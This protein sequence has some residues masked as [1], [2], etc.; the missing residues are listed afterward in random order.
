[1]V[2]SPEH[3]QKAAQR[4]GCP[5]PK[6]CALVGVGI[7]IGTLGGRSGPIHHALKI[8]RSNIQ[9]TAP[10]HSEEIVDVLADD[11]Q[12]D[13]SRKPAAGR[14]SAMQRILAREADR[15]GD[16]VSVSRIGVRQSRYHAPRATG[17]AARTNYPP[18]PST[19]S[20]PHSCEEGDRAGWHHIHR[21]LW[22]P[23]TA[24]RS[25]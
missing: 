17:S 23:L 2:L 7:G 19:R 8:Q 13:S 24:E 10:T 1:V 4:Q 11:D 18:I 5:A 9:Q 12:S 3:Q 6:K 14:G 16:V 20:M 21:P 22:P 25:A 15:V